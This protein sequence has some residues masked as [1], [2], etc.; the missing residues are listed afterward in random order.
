M[1]SDDDNF[2]G[3][4]PIPSQTITIDVAQGTPVDKSEPKA[5]KKR[6]KIVI[7]KIQMENSKCRKSNRK[8]GADK[9]QTV[10]SGHTSASPTKKHS[11]G[12]F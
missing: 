2:D 12:F 7:K 3:T 8:E 10:M 1:P 4:T 9:A 11:I 5:T 6:N